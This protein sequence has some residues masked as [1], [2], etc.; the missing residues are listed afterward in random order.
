MTHK[1]HYNVYIASCDEKGGIYHYALREDGRLCEKSFTPLDHP[2]FLHIYNNRMYAVLRSPFENS[3]ESGLISFDIAEDGA[4]RDPSDV[5]STKGEVSCHLTVDGDVYCVNYISGSVIKMPSGLVVHKGKGIHPTRQTSPHPHQ[6][7]FTPDKKYLCVTDL[8]LDKIIVYDRE[9]NGISSVSLPPGSGARHLAFSP[10]GQYAYCAN[11]LA[12]SVTA[13]D[14]CGGTLTPL[15]TYSAL[16]SGFQGENTAAAI[17]VSNGGSFVYVSNRGHDSIA[18]FTVSGNTLRL[19]EFVPCGGSSPR[20]FNISPDERFLIC[21][22]ENSDNVCVFEMKNGI[23]EK[24][25][26][27]V[28]IKSPLCVLYD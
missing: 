18:C 15:E 25:Q 28:N 4:L 16:P 22:N 14:Y 20:D 24:T 6:I 7:I 10:D 2:M 8:G 23:P 21:T 3:K 27:D 17:R 13:L 19:N 1:R 9:L 5:V 26:Y 11:E 12:S